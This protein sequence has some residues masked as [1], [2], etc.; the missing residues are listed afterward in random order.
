MNMVRKSKDLPPPWRR[1]RDRRFGEMVA[2]GMTE[3]T[4]R[5]VAGAEAA[6]RARI[7]E[8]VG[9]RAAA[10]AT[11]EYDSFGDRFFL[12]IDPNKVPAEKREWAERRLNP[13]IIM[14]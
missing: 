10:G 9:Y 2:S 12:L 4:A 7:A 13:G 3:A 8:I 6:G 1:W 11:V 14:P 5:K